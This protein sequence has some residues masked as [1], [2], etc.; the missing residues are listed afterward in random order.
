MLVAILTVSLPV[1]APR[2]RC[3]PWLMN[4]ASAG[5]TVVNR[6]LNIFGDLSADEQMKLFQRVEG[7][8][9]ADR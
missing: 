7:L 8:C 9:E 4:L 6:K 5:S 1:P 2:T 3:Q